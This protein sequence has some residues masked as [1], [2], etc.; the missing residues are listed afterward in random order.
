[1]C[2]V[3]S[4][5]SGIHCFA[6]PGTVALQAPLSMGSSG[7]TG[8]GC[9]FLLQGIFPSLGPNLSLLGPLH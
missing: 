5:F 3:L 1:M 6:T 7:N 2:R 4:C 9:P 8:V